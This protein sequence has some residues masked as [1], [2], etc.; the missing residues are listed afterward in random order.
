MQSKHP[1]P[2]QTAQSFFS[3]LQALGSFVQSLHPGPLHLVQSLSLQGHFPGILQSWHPGPLH[4]EHG[5]SRQVHLVGVNKQLI[6]PGP[7]H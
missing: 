4:S 6:H 2:S 1:S 3:Q 7:L 5:L